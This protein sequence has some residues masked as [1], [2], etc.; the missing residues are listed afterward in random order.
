MSIIVAE[1]ENVISMRWFFLND[2][3]NNNLKKM[4]GRLLVYNWADYHPLIDGFD[5]TTQI[6]LYMMSIC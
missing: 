2:F 4:G 1:E 5:K 6:C 3:G